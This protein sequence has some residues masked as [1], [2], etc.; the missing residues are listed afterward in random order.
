MSFRSRVERLRDVKNGDVILPEDKN[1]LNDALRELAR[2]IDVRDDKLVLRG[3]LIEDLRCSIC[4]EELK[5]GDPIVFMVGG[6][7]L[8]PVHL[9]CIRE[10]RIETKRKVEKRGK[11]IKDL[12]VEDE[13]TLE[14]ECTVANEIVVK[15]GGFLRIENAKLNFLDCGITC[16][17]S[18][19]ISNSSLIGLKNILLYKTS[20]TVTDTTFENGMSRKGKEI[21]EALELSY[22]ESPLEEKTYG[23]A[24]F[25]HQSELTMDNIKMV[26]CYAYKG[27]CIYCN[28][29]SDIIA[30]SCEFLNCSAEY[31]GATIYF[32][33]SKGKLIDCK[34]KDCFAKGQGALDFWGGSIGKLQ[35]CTFEN[36]KDYAI[37][38]GGDNE[39]KAIRCR[40]V[41]CRVYNTGK[42]ECIDCEGL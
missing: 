37:Y 23:G 10:D 17:G 25:L 16:K 29:K 19:E 30:Q 12:K 38:I 4:G 27:S 18:L 21:N 24:I 41:D 42:F 8:I 3:F 11:I 33:N 22:Y 20:A 35:D 13:V 2:V 26:R 36:C 6:E 32:F 31:S 34:F 1:E 14:G 28:N 40:F 7:G 5:S 39:V 9:R 15:E